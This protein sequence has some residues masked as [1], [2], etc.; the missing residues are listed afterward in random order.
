[1]KV[2]LI[3]KKSKRGDGGHCDICYYY[4]EWDKQ[5]FCHNPVACND[6]TYIRIPHFIVTNGNKNEKET[7]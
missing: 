4:S 1:M 3:I 7:N 2:Y 5:M 6:R